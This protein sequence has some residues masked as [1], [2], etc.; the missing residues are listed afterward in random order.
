MALFPTAVDAEGVMHSNTAFG[1]YPQYYPGIKQDAVDNNFTGWMLL[2]LKKYVEVSSTLEG[3]KPA[4]AVD[5]D[6]MTHWSATT[7]NPGEYMT[8][9]LGKECNVYALQINFDQQDVKLQQGQGSGIGG[10]RGL[11]HYHVLYCPC[12]KR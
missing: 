7:G 10:A 9:D 12:F 11:D 1:D 6:F 8:V 5:E 3:Y 4:N 2:S